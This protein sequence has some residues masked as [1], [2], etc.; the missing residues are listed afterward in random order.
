MSKKNQNSLD[1]YLIDNYIIQNK[2]NILIKK[3]IK[4]KNSIHTKKGNEIQILPKNIQIYFQ[5]DRQS[6]EIYD[7]GIIKLF[8]DID[9]KRSTSKFTIKELKQQRLNLIKQYEKNN[10]YIIDFSRKL[11]ERTVKLSFHLIHKTIAFT[12]IKGLT[13]FV[14]NNYEYEGL[15]MM[16]KSYFA[17]RLPLQSKWNENNKKVG[18]PLNTNLIN[19]FI[20]YNFKNYTIYDY[21]DLEISSFK[22][23]L[24]I[25]DKL[26]IQN[27]LNIL[28]PEYYDNYDLWVKIHYALKNIKTFDAYD[29]FIN[30][31]KKSKKF[32]LKDANRLWLSPINNSIN[33]ITPKT[34]YYFAKLSNLKKFTEI[35]NPPNLQKNFMSRQGLTYQDFTRKWRNKKI[36]NI[37][38]FINDIRQ[39]MGYYDSGN[40]IYIFKN[41]NG[42]ALYKKHNLKNY[43]IFLLDDNKYKKQSF[44]SILQLNK[45]N[46]I[47]Y[48]DIIFNPEKTESNTFNL[49]SGFKSQPR[50]NINLIKPI[51]H[52]IKEIWANGITERYNYIINWLA[53][54]IQKPYEKNGTVLVFIGPQGCGKNILCNFLMHDLIGKR[55]STT[56]KNLNKITQRFNSL[57]EHKLLITL[58]EVS[59]IEKNYHKTFDLLKN[60]I[61]ENTQQLERKGL[62]P[63]TIN[64]Y[65]N[66]IML[67][68][69]YYPVKVEGMDRRYCIFDCSGRYVSNTDYFIKLKKSFNQKT[70]DA[71]HD[72]L[73]KFDITKF[74]LS[75]IPKSKIKDELVKKSIPDIIYFLKNLCKKH[76]KKTFSPQ[77]LWEKYQNYCINNMI[78]IKKKNSFLIIISRYL[79]KDRLYID[80][81]RIRIYICDYEYFKKQVLLINHYQF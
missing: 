62:D 50:Q 81:K 45:N 23:I 17:F 13:N 47:Q 4:I 2:K 76:N 55:Y 34:I 39:V 36:D 26:T 58:D 25:Y 71:F 51:L 1:N 72:F 40:P 33:Q 21:L 43:P 54:I 37:I 5:K 42:V 60:L 77:I 70:A 66:Y 6:L 38:N 49:W 14:K 67:S 29:L 68:N 78:N 73:L 46:D 48:D 59:N 3:Y 22:N 69:N 53:N 64:D 30:F 12:N 27:L 24:I 74:E 31:S 61:T 80:K 19:C 11:D 41:K 16:Y 20:T 57:L 7:G 15:D 8:I 28:S 65:C 9:I 75:I 44:W 35:L 18:K 63:I 32:N 79:K 52:H 56:I 10:F